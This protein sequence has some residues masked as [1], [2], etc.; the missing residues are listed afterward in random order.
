MRVFL[1]FAL[2]LIACG[3]KPHVNIAAPPPNLT[4]D[5]RVDAFN[6]LRTEATG[7]EVVTTCNH[8]CTSTSTPLLRIGAGNVV[9]YAEDLLPVLPQGSPA[10]AA[11]HDVETARHKAKRVS[12]IGGLVF[13][14]GFVTMM[15]AFNYGDELALI[16]GAT[17]AGGLI[18]WA[19]GVYGYDREIKEKTKLVFNS[20]DESLAT[21]FN[22]CVNGMNVVACEQSTPGTTPQEPDPALKALRQK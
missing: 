16:G 6:K 1:C 12:R 7:V 11:A 14:A 18:G 13:A 10:A 5:Q 8:G 20:Y 4:P 17:M 19:Y 22:V 15:L 2:L 9:R 21:T 3:E